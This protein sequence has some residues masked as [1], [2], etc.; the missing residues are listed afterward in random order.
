MKRT[1]IILILMNLMFF[2]ISI[3]IFFYG[4][5]GWISMSIMSMIASTILS[6]FVYKNQKEVHLLLEERKRLMKE[7][8]DIPG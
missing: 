4:T 6:I 3:S 5:K 7:L 2:I 1:K 8:D